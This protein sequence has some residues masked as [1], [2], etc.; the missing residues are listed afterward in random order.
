MLLKDILVTLVILVLHTTVIFIAKRGSRGAVRSVLATV[1]SSFATHQP[2]LPLF[3]YIDDLAFLR[4]GLLIISRRHTH[5]TFVP[6]PRAGLARSGGAHNNLFPGGASVPK[7]DGD[8]VVAASKTTAAAVWW[9]CKGGER[10]A[11]QRPA[12]GQGM[13]ETA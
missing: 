3:P 6:A 13:R 11:I 4:L 7:G 2:R 1:H 8:V 5:A 12:A 10:E 9:Q